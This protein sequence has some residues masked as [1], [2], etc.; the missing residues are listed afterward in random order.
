[1][2]DGAV[3]ECGGSAGPERRE[4]SAARKSLE[5]TIDG[6]P[7]C[8][9]DG[10]G[11][12]RMVEPSLATNTEDA[13]IEENCTKLC[14]CQIDVDKDVP[15][16]LELRMI[17]TTGVV[18]C[19]NE[20]GLLYLTILQ[21]CSLSRRQALRRRSDGPLYMSAYGTAF[22]DCGQQVLTI[23]LQSCCYYVCRLNKKDDI[24][25]AASL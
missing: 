23:E 16:D 6:S 10:S 25:D 21:G 4:M 3:F 5:K 11:H 22:H 9:D 12:G 7:E 24:S 20:E 2:L 13:A 8:D 1:M 14:A 18:I 19:T 15:G 17:S